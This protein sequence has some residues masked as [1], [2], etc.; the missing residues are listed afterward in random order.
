MIIS[1]PFFL[2]NSQSVL[3]QYLPVYLKGFK[4]PLLEHSLSLQGVRVDVFLDHSRDSSSVKFPVHFT[5]GTL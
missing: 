5:H 3:E 2:L 4:S 1:S